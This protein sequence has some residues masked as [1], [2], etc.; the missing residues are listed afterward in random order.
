[1]PDRALGGLAPPSFVVSPDVDH[2]PAASSGQSVDRR[3]SVKHDERSESTASV[4][5]RTT[6]QN[7]FGMTSSPSIAND[8]G[9]GSIAE[10]LNPTNLQKLF[11]SV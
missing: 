4:P 7:L 2:P 11:I 8:Q 10:T 3:K 1:M 9:K 5:V 6:R